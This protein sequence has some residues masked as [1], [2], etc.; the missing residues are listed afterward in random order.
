VLESNIFLE[1]MLLYYKTISIFAPGA[2]RA[3]ETRG[4]MRE[5]EASAR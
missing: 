2:R 4:A 1:F 5:G 3:P